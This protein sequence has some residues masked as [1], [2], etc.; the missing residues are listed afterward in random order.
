MLAPFGPPTIKSLATA[1]L[2]KDI[3][4]IELNF[5]IDILGSNVK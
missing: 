3:K 4:F 1:L 2:Y 5:E